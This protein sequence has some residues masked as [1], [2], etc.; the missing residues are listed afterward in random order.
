[1][2]GLFNKIRNGSV[3]PTESDPMTLMSSPSTSP[4]VPRV[5]LSRAKSV[6]PSIQARVN[7]KELANRR[8]A[9]LTARKS[10]FNLDEVLNGADED[11]KNLLLLRQGLSPD[12]TE[13]I[14]DEFDTPTTSTTKARVLSSSV[15]SPASESKAPEPVASTVPTEPAEPVLNEEELR[16]QLQKDAVERMNRL[17]EEQMEALRKQREEKEKQN[18]ADDHE[19][20][21]DKERRLRMERLRMLQEENEDFLSEM[22][23]QEH[24]E[25]FN[26]PTLSS[27]PSEIEA[28]LEKE[29][30]EKEQLE[31]EEKQ[32][33]IERNKALEVEKQKNEQ[34]EKEKAQKLE[35]ERIKKENE[36]AEQ[37][38]IEEE[39]FNKERLEKER[40]EAQEQ[41]E[42]ERIEKAKLEKERLEKERLEKERLEKERLEKERLEKEKL[43]EERSEKERLEKERLEK[44]R[45][46]AQRLESERL[47]KERLEKE[48]LEKLEVERIE[49]ERKQKEKEKQELEAAAAKLE[50]LSID[51]SRI[52]SLDIPY[53]CSLLSANEPS[54]KSL[55]LKG[56]STSQGV[57][58]C[59]ACISNTHLITLDFTNSL[60]DQQIVPSLSS[61]IKKNKHIKNLYLENTFITEYNSILDALEENDVI[62]DMTLG[63]FA[64]EDDENDLDELLGKN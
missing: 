52:T 36:L 12:G 7:G 20:Q 45:L 16:E 6:S 26:S 9:R 57:S 35:E 21:E 10:Q 40:L 63:K 48:R 56:A 24:S 3:S 11:A 14:N 62:A 59:N 55:D 22:K 49:N 4:V 64:T 42:K 8:S 19:Q 60:I 5:D 51:Q 39:R 33:E 25:K 1:M 29:R 15:S 23:D 38:R 47:E 54:L 18:S 53:I 43:E 27:G 46:E 13:S 34:L 2:K 58:I 32:K 30:L 28:S 37:K 41:A 31:A 61:L 44:E 50:K 17:K